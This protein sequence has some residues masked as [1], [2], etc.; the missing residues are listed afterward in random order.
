[1]KKKKTFLRH[2]LD[3]TLILKLVIQFISYYSSCIQLILL[4]M[5]EIVNNKC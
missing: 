1:M 5:N 4:G 3:T 2:I